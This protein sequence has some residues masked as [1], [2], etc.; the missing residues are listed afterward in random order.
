MLEMD[1]VGTDGMTINANIALAQ[2]QTDAYS[3][4]CDFHEYMIKTNGNC[5]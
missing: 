5:V 1:L 2:T 3:V 4:E